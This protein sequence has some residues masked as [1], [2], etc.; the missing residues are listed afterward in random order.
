M[1]IN[2]PQMLNLYFC[3]IYFFVKTMKKEARC[4]FSFT[5]KL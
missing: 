5:V 3:V 4:R 2:E 1:K